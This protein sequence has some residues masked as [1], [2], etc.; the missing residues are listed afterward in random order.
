MN[1]PAIYVL[2]KIRPEAPPPKGGFLG[3][4]PARSNK[5]FTKATESQNGVDARSW[6]S[7]KLIRAALK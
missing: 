6:R 1:Y 3:I 2:I 4:T 5:K 7:V